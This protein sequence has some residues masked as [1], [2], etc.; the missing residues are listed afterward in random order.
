MSEINER[1]IWNSRQNHPEL[2]VMDARAAFGLDDAQCEHLRF[3][4]MNRGV[5]KWLF[6]R[7]R[8]ID[9]KHDFKDWLKELPPGTPLH[10]KVQAFNARMQHI[11]KC[12]RWVEWGT[13]VHRRMRENEREIVV[14]GKPC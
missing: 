14:R 10:K 6:A 5:N 2:V 12:P 7:T 3:I 11:A 13:R 8:F 4:L 1:T 9:L